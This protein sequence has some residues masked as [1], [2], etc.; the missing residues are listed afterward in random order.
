MRHWPSQTN[1]P[2]TNQQQRTG[3]NRGPQQQ[4]LSGRSPTSRRVRLV[5]P[6]PIKNLRRYF[7]CGLLFGSPSPLNRWP[8]VLIDSSE[9]RLQRTD[10]ST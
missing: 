6:V 3:R 7:N 5:I 4:A 10:N 1:P 8:Q 9:Q 2:G